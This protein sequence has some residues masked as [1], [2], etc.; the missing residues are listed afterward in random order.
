MSQHRLRHAPASTLALAQV[1]IRA[2]VGS[3]CVGSS[4]RRTPMTAML[5]LSWLPPVFAQASE[6]LVSNL[7]EFAGT[8]TVW[9]AVTGLSRSGKTVFITS[10]IHNL[11][12]ALQSP[13]RMPLLEMVG[14]RRLIAATL[15]SSKAYRLPRFPYFSNIE[16]M[17]GS[18]PDWP[19]RTLDLSEIGLEIRFTP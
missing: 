19:R 2:H 10:L 14:A 9:L 11:L 13:G 12:S 16:N 15:E 3:Q 6:R 17:A 7:S 5:N 18:R 8:A 1:R 4:A